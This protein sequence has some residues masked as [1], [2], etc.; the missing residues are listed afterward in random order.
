MV[1]EQG[2]IKRKDVEMLLDISQTMAGRLLKKL[3]E[4][5]QLSRKGKASNTVYV[6][7]ED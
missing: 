6:I 1:K 4:E 2:K 7:K 3:I 5:N